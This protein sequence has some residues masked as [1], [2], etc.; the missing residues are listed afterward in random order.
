MKIKQGLLVWGSTT[1][2][3]NP[4]LFLVSHEVKFNPDIWLARSVDNPEIYCVFH[5]DFMK[6]V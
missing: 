5:K 3:D 1:W 6:P 4:R 2:F